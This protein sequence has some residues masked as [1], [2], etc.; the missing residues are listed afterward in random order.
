MEQPE[1]SPF[2]FIYEQDGAMEHL[3]NVACGLNSMVLG[4]TQILGQVRSSFLLAQEENTIGTV[5]NQFLNKLLH[6][7]NV[8]TLKRISV[9]MRY[10]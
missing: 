9:Q 2:L 4:E 3:F 10:R 8:L 7:Q 1:F 5:F 6:L